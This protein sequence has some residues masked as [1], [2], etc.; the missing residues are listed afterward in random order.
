[1]RKSLV[2]AMSMIMGICVTDFAANPFSDVSAGHWVYGSIPKLATV[3]VVDGYP[4]G[5]F[6]GDNLMT[7]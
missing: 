4:Y 6:K 2:L 5:T 3:S 1:M 7:R